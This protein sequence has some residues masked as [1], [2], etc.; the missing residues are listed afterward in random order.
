VEAKR[1]RVMKK[2]NE[3][4]EKIKKKVRAE[5]IERQRNQRAN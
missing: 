5:M 2:L 3:K 4:A 1:N